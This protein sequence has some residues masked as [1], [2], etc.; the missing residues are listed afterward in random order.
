[1]KQKKVL[2]VIISLVL[3]FSLVLAG[4]STTPEQADTPPASVE[5]ESGGATDKAPP[6]DESKYVIGVAFDTQ[7]DFIS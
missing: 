7:V 5:T 6:A 4:C 1:M 3:V 2:S